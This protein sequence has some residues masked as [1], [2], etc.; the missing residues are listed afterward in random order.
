MI[1]TVSTYSMPDGSVVEADNSELMS[2]KSYYAHNPH[3]AQK[4]WDEAAKQKQAD[5]LFQKHLAGEE[6]KSNSSL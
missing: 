4:E 2:L 5:E 3:I 1:R 6:L